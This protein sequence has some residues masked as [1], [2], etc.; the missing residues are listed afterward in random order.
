M[1]VLRTVLLWLTGDD[2]QRDETDE[3]KWI[4]FIVHICTLVTTPHHHRRCISISPLIF[5][6][7]LPNMLVEDLEEDIRSKV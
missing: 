1:W 3:T 2:E 6:L 5:E 4:K 7:K